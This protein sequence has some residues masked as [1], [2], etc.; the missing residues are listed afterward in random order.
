MAIRAAQVN[1]YKNL[2]EQVYG[3]H[4]AGST[5]VSAF[6]AQSDTAR[7]HVDAFIRGARVVSTTAIA[8]GNYEVTVELDMTPSFLG[9]FAP[10]GTCSPHRVTPSTA[11]CVSYGCVSPSAGY[12]S[13]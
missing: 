8:D 3:F 2:A 1:A 5:V 9:C 7:A 11:G 10:Q 6:A 4:I 13:Y 12:H